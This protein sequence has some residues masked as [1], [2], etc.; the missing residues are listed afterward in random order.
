MGGAPCV[1][2]PAKAEALLSWRVQVSKVRVDELRNHLYFTI[3]NNGVNHFL[4]RLSGSCGGES[5]FKIAFMS[6]LPVR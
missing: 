3:A 2:G 5:A 6:V 1:Y 4:T